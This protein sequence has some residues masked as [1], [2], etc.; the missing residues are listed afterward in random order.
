MA[1]GRK[2]KNGDDTGEPASMAGHNVGDRGEAIRAAFRRLEALDSEIKALQE[3]RSAFKNEEIKGKLG[4]KVADFNAAY[5]LY[6]LE[7]DDRDAMLDTLRECFDALGA[8]EQLDWINIA[9]RRA[10]GSRG[11]AAEAAAAGSA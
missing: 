5:R 1:R 10:A 9:E 4:M 8:G 2:Q 7:G 6:K 11:E 3:D